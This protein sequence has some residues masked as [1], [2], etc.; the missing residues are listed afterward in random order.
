MAQTCLNCQTEITGNF[1]SNCGQKKYK[2]IDRSYVSDE[3][4]Y[5]VLHMN[6]GF[7]YSI[8]QLLKNP[9]R[10]A[11]EYIDGNRVNHYKP[12]LLVFVLAGISTLIS[13]K[14]IGLGDIM[15]EYYAQMKMESEF[16][17]DWMTFIQ[18]S[19]S[20]LMLMMV[21]FFAFA[22]RIAFYN[23]GHNYFEHIVLNAY[24]L[25]FY[26]LVS[27][28]ILN[29]IIY[30]FRSEPQMVMMISSCSALMGIPLLVWFYRHVYPEQSLGRII[31]GVLTSAL[32]YL[33]LAIILGLI[34]L[35]VFA[36][37]ASGDPES[38]KYLQPKK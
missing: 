8:K 29:P 2:R 28:I 18:S 12:L 20:L 7:F 36:I 6:K 25:S 33:F 11:R 31:V 22:T 16:T 14:V 30:I 32:L 13:Y 24:F 37:I 38:L 4:Q 17:N 27:I 21:P 23:L 9:G 1:C 15:R 26:T 34:M 10:T 19:N 3:L 35:V 5:T